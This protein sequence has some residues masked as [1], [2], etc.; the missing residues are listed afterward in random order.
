MNSVESS[1]RATRVTRTLI[2][3]R[4]LRLPPSPQPPPSDADTFERKH[5]A[6]FKAAQEAKLRATA[7]GAGG[8]GDEAFPMRPGAGGGA[9]GHSWPPSKEPNTGAPR[10]A[11]EDQSQGP[12]NARLMFGGIPKG[13]VATAVLLRYA[14]V[15]AKPVQ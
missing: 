13:I 12:L 11:A 10:G 1:Q 2:L 15:Q 14:K 4:L 9:E 3:L 6:L 8:G 7:V 5:P